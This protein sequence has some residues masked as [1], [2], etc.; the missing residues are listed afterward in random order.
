MV[1]DNK[2]LTTLIEE[3]N[4]LLVLR[5]YLKLP[6]TAV[7]EHIGVSEQ[8][9][10]RQEQGLVSAPKGAASRFAW[11]LLT[12]TGEPSHELHRACIRALAQLQALSVSAYHGRTEFTTGLEFEQF[13]GDWWNYWTLVKRQNATLNPRPLTIYGYCRRLALHPYIV[14]NYVKQ[15]S[16]NPATV[17][18]LSVMEAIK[19]TGQPLSWLSYL[20]MLVRA[21]N[22]GTRTRRA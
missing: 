5:N 2:N 11:D 22:N 13:V 17:I 4:P 20:D 7:A 18:P 12:A 10:R 9:I 15:L 8:Y 19:Q 14:Q 16:G 3:L 6:Q 21:T 1:S